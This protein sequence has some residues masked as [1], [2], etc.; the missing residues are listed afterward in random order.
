M[1]SKQKSQ[2]ILLALSLA[3]LGIGQALLILGRDFI[4]AQQPVDWTHWLIL[5]GAAG[6]ACA[7]GSMSFGKVGR[8]GRGLLIAGSVAFICMAGIDFFLWALPSNEIINPILDDALDKPAISI[9]LLQIGPSLFFVGLCL[10]GIEWRRVSQLGASLLIAGT[11]ISGIGQA[12]RVRWIV[13][14]SFLIMLAGLF[15]IWPKART[16]TKPSK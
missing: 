15:L 7:V 16:T 11:L 2:I 8:L 5:V 9:P 12:A 14:V 13:A 3:V 10:L 4:R 1:H 6:A